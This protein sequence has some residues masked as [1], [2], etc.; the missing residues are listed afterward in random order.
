[1]LASLIIL[2]FIA[3]LLVSV[4][5]YIRFKI[6]YLLYEYNR[7]YFLILLIIH[8][9]NFILCLYDAYINFDASILICHLSDRD[10]GFASGSVTESSV[11]SSG[12]DGDASS[13]GDSSSNQSSSSGRSN[14][15]SLPRLD[16]T[17]DLRSLVNNTPEGIV[18]SNSSNFPSGSEKVTVTPTSFSDSHLG[19]NN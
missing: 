12:Y 11:G 13:S 2:V 15:N 19:K 8:M 9:C 6:L 5:L 4:R 1:M 7:L 17:N 3:I 16:G 10:S 14:S 18:N